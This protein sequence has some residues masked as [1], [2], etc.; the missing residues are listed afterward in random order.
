MLWKKFRSERGADGTGVQ[1]AVQAQ[2]V[3]TR[4]QT[5]CP[6]TRF[7]SVRAVREG[8]RARTRRARSAQAPDAH[9]N[10]V[11][12]HPSSAPPT[13]GHG[14]IGLGACAGTGHIDENG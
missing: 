9:V 1:P 6:L 2:Q 8:G 4:S 10:G 12:T 14:H 7:V 11:V 5:F 3:G 13:H